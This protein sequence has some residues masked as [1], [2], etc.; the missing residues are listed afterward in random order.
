MIE[1]SN[2]MLSNG[3][4]RAR[5]CKVCGKEGLGGNIKTH[6]ETYHL[7]LAI[8]CTNCERVFKSRAMEK[9]HNCKMM[10]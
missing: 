5:K 1:L 4:Q 9:A 10:G 2:N 6:I 3:K 8:P 7:Q